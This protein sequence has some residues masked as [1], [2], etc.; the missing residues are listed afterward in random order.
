M[1]AGGTDDGG[2]AGARIGGAFGT[3]RGRTCLGPGKIME[4]YVGFQQFFLMYAKLITGLSDS[5]AR[6]FEVT[7]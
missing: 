1:E 2:P 6:V 4:G 5:K 3:G 7:P